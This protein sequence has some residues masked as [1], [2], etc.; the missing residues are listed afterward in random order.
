MRCGHEFFFTKFVK[1][2]DFLERRR[3]RRCNKK[4]LK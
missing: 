2:E 4:N 3:F 1:G